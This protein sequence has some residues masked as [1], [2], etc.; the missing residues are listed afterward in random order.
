[1]VGQAM[2]Q[3]GLQLPLPLLIS[4]IG[5]MATPFIGILSER[6]GM[7]LKEAWFVLVSAASLGGVYQLYNIV[8]AAPDGVLLL[9]SWGQAPPLSGCLEI[10]MLGVYMSFSIAFLGLLV[11]IY[12][13]SYM[14][15][16]TRVAEFYTLVTFMIAGMFGIVFAGDLFTLFVFWELMG[17][18]SY[19]LVSFLK[20]NWGPIEAGFKYLLMS[21]TAGAFLLLSMALL[22]G[23]TGTLNFGMLANSIRGNPLTPWTVLLFSTLIVGFG[24]K[25][26]I[27]PMHT[28]LPDAHPEAPSPISALLSGVVIE[29]GLYGL[30][31]LLFVVFEPSVFKLPIAALA[32]LTM[33]VGNLLALLQGD[34]KRMLAYSSIAQIGYMLVGLSAGTVYGA[35]GLFLHVF[36]HSM[37]KGLAFLAAGSLIHIGNTRNIEDLKGIGRAMPLTTMGLFVSF[38]G[39]G[40]V[41]ATSG[42]ISKFMLFSSAIEVG[43][44]WL[45]VI[46]VLNSALS[47]AYYLRV[48]K[49]LISDPIDSMKGLKEAPKLMVAVT[50]V[51]TLVVILF[52]VWPEPAVSFAESA[53]EALVNGFNAYIGAI[54]G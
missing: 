19:V 9:Y 20:Q 15:H 33:T 50:V 7:K 39:L 40:G 18:S 17:L 11:S 16:E 6:T 35:Q 2:I 29:T 8:K 51:M 32:V 22:Y 34:L 47:M 54:I 13:I 43:M 14:E 5:A 28:W 44:T 23:L 1:M 31:R 26:A 30:T 25:S 3:T 37:M 21:A 41:P 48:I 42:F 10:D 12:S 45:T 46:G 4:L 49:T 24:V 52:G 36:N 27:V 53:A 38:M